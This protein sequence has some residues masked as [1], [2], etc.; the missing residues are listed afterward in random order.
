MIEVTC[1]RCRKPWI[2]TKQNYIVGSWRVCDRCRSDALRRQGDP[3]TKSVKN[4][5]ELVLGNG[6]DTAA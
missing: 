6:P 1:I 5:V 2:P 3:N 4:L